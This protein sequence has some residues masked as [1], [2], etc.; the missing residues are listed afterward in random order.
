MADLTIIKRLPGWAPEGQYS[1][2]AVVM[3][4][5][6]GRVQAKLLLHL[7]L[8]A[9][10]LTAV[11]CGGPLPPPDPHNLAGAK[12]SLSRG[13]HWYGL[14]CY[15][16][17]EHYF[18]EGLDF[19]RMSDDVLLIIRAQNSLGA[20]ALAR[21]EVNLAAAHLELALN[22]CQAQPDRPELDK[23]LGNLGSLAFKLGRLDDANDF[24]SQALEVAEEHGQNPALYLCDLA[25]LNLVKNN[26]AEFLELTARALAATENEPDLQVRA[27]ALNLAGQAALLEDRLEEAESLYRQALELDRKT[28][29][30]TGLAQDTESLGLL[31]I[32]L[33]RHREAAGF[34]DRS[35]YLWL[36]VGDDRKAGQVLAALQR[37]SKEHGFPQ[38]L[39]VYQ[40]S[41]RNPAP[42]RLTKQ[43][44]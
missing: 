2:G 35:F 30:T 6:L 34:L 13:N 4:G 40:Q 24:W 25:Q 23:I 41:L 42:H 21:G 18:A 26:R 38:K 36:A 37:L 7:I 22:S 12:D 5:R 3:S 19:A 29:N 32:R 1:V 16:E 31:M 39:S 14:G 17:A 9:A 8:A 11:G 43:C 44:P 27:D 33:E 10:L 20:A 28:E 15:V